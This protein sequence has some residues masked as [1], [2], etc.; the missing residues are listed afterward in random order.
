[1]TDP[2]V[3]FAVGVAEGAE[4]EILG[5]LDRVRPIIR[6]GEGIGPVAATPVGALLSML[7]RVFPHTAL[8]GDAPMGPNPWGASRLSD[9]P[10]LLAPSRPTPTREP[11][12]TVVVGVGIEHDAT[13]WMGGDDWTA[14]VG[15]TPCPVTAGRFGLGLHVSA[16]L[17]AAE[18]SKIALGT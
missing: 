10:R 13:L 7:V 6:L 11:D 1:M 17:V 8:A 14:D 3:A 5:M 2:R 12:L 15:R 4:A 9:L 16:I 18:M